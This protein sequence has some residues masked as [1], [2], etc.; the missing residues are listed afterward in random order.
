[1]CRECSATALANRGTAST[2]P[3]AKVQRAE[4]RRGYRD[5]VEGSNPG[6]VEQ[7]ARPTVARSCM[8]GDRSSITRPDGEHHHIAPIGRAGDDL[9]PLRHQLLVASRECAGGEILLSDRTSKPIPV[10]LRLHQEHQ[11]VVCVPRRRDRINARSL[12]TPSPRSRRALTTSRNAPRDEG[13]A[14]ALLASVGGV[15]A[16]C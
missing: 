13:R 5:A 6:V 1:M 15:S 9:Q 8:R 12:L 11:P 4:A 3:S 14:V 10:L 7:A 16:T 2:A